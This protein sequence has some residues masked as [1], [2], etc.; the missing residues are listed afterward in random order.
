GSGG[1]RAAIGDAIGLGVKRWRTGP[2][3]SRVL[4][5]LTDGANNVGEVPPEKAAELARAEGVRIYTVGVGAEELK[6]PGFWGELGGHIVNPSA[7]LDAKTL[8]QI[9][10]TTGGPFFRAHD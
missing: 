5:L 7:E 9:A 3:E 2:A 10:S 8:E 1:G 4:I 6:V